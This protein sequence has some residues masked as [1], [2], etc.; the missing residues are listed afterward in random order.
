MTALK[1]ILTGILSFLLLL[2]VSVFGIALLV[3]CTALNPDFVTA[4]ADRADIVEIARDVVDEYV[5]DE[6][7]EDVRFFEDVVYEAVVC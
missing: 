6:I 5:I 2:S 4:Q 7:P 3:N 1:G